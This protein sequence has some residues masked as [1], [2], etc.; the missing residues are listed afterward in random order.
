[1]ATSFFIE[2]VKSTATKN[3]FAAVVHTIYKND[4]EFIYPIEKQI[5]NIFNPEKNPCFQYGTASRW[6]IKDDKGNVAGRIAAFINERKIKN[7]PYPVG[8]IGFF[9]CIDNTEAAHLLFNT[10]M[11]WLY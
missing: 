8:A 3:A 5:E 10:A 11:P 6:I 1:M 9:E 2:E 4:P 7:Q